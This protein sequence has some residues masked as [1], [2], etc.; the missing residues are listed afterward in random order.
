[1]GEWRSWTDEECA[2]FEERWPPGTMQR[3]A[4]A[5]GLYTGQRKQD[6]VTRTRDHR[7]DGGIHVVQGKTGKELWIPEHRELTAELARGVVGFSS[8]LVTPVQG[9][10]FSEEYFGA[11]FAEPIED[12]GLPREC[13]LHGLRKTAARKLAELGLATED[14]KSVTGHVTGRMVDKYVKGADQRSAPP[15]R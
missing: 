10:P 2:K 8:L 3:R 15:G 11:W 12:A 6:L 4:Y 14:I 7:I 1:V 9:K 5:L 13:V